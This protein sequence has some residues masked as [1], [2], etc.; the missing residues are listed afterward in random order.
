[1]AHLVYQPCSDDD[2]GENLQKTILNPL[3]LSRIRAW[4][5]EALYAK[6]LIENPDGKVFVW[7]VVPSSNT[8]SSYAK[9]S[10]GDVVIFNRKTII[11]VAA[12]VTYK[13]T[14]KNLAIELWGYKSREEQTTWENIYFLTDVRHL[15]IPFRAI[16]QHVKSQQRQCFYRFNES[17]SESAFAAFDQLQSMSLGPVPTLADVKAE[18]LANLTVDGVGSAPTR[19]EHRYIVDHLFGKN[20]EGS[21]S[22]CGGVFPR[23]MLV[24]SHIKKRSACSRDEKLDVQ[25]VATAMCRLGCDPLFELGFISVLEGK[26]V[27]HPSRI[28]SELISSYID[29]LVGRPV[30]AWTKKTQ[31]YFQWHAT[32]HGYGVTPSKP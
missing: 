17:D 16:Q 11:T 1:M 4:L 31:K 15:S 30:I 10:P 8:N 20:A 21:C 26:V 24:A 9:L 12:T 28:G 19:G 32:A 7:G 6:L 3:P 13:L 27:R 5:P 18:I 23:S 2:A 22:I 29:K 14:S 25:N